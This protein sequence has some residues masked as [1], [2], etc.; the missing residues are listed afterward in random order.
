MMRKKILFVINTLGGAGAETAMMELL[1]SLPPQQYEVSLFVLM[2]QGEMV[3]QL[4][5]GE[6][7]PEPIYFADNV[8]EGEFVQKFPL[9]FVQSVPDDE[10]KGRS[11]G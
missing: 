9:C 1:R 7:P 4:P 3:H 10:R 11:A 6:E 5:G 2:N 8:P